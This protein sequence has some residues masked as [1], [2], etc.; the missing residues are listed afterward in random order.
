MRYLKK[1]LISVYIY[2]GIFAI[3][4]YIGWLITGDEPSALIAGVFGAGGIESL[5]GGIIKFR[6]I[7]AEKQNPVPQNPQDGE[8]NNR[9]M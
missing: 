6:E 1:L 2:L 7:A 3:A 8:M 5:V 9:G 4:V